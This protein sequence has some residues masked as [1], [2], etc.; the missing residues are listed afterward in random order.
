MDAQHI[1]VPL[2]DMQ[3][4]ALDRQTGT[5]VWAR[6]LGAPAPPMT[7]EGVLFVVGSGEVHA[8]EP[9]T[10]TSRWVTPLANGSL[11]ALAALP[12]QLLVASTGGALTAIRAED[13]ERLWE[14]ALGA[15]AR[16]LV[17]DDAG[18]RAYLALDG[19]RLVAVAVDD[20]RLLWEQSLPGTLSVPTPAVGRVFVGSSDNFFY[21][22][23]ARDGDLH[24]RWRVGGDVV[25]AVADG[26]TVY[27]VALDNLVRALNR[28]SG[29]Q[30]WRGELESRP[31][32]APQLFGSTLVVTD[33][34]P[35]V[36]TL[37]ASSGGVLASF[38]A[39]GDL[40]GPPLIDPDA[41]LGSV[42]VA[43][44]MSDGRVVGLRPM[45][46]EPPV[47]DPPDD[48]TAEPVIAP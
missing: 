29:N 9:E 34:S 3:L 35:A 38:A 24:W 10:G 15:S 44:I 18:E 1:Y 27:V 6:A 11:A 33:I 41:R 28:G 43:L 5:V 14:Q 21:A 20:G 7:L 45:T 40:A 37:D 4:V 16:A 47:P 13:G 48:V 46:P 32:S 19:G 39:P 23:D 42:A 22:L 31:G 30:R 8:L 36:S 17:V 2:Q 12:D 25:G 26:D